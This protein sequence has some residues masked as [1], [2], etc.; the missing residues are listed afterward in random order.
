MA[1]LW[2][3]QIDP[4][5]GGYVVGEDGRYAKGPA[6]LGACHALCATDGGSVP[7]GPQFRSQLR[8]LGTHLYVGV[9]AAVQSSLQAALRQYDG[10]L[11]ASSSVRVWIEDGE[12]RYEATVE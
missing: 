1:R 10:V 6:A 8:E 7:D 4:D 3:R 12:L 2:T 11:W 9:T 5:T